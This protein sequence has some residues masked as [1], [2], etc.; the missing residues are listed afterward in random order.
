MK[1]LHNNINIT[2][3]PENESGRGGD[4]LSAPNNK[5]VN[6]MP[7]PDKRQAKEEGRKIN[8]A[9]AEKGLSSREIEGQ[10]LLFREE[11]DTKPKEYSIKTPDG[12][13]RFFSEEEYAKMC[14]EMEKVDEDKNKMTPEEQKKSYF[15]EKIPEILEEKAQTDDYM[16]RRNMVGG[17]GS[18][19]GANPQEP[20]GLDEY[21][22][23]VDRWRQKSENKKRQEE[24]EKDTYNIMGAVVAEELVGAGKELAQVPT[25][26]LTDLM[27]ELEKEG[28]NLKFMIAIVGI[29]EK[30]VSLPFNMALGAARD[31]E[32]RY[33]VKWNDQEILKEVA[34]NRAK[35]RDRSRPTAKKAAE[36]YESPIHED[37]YHNNPADPDNNALAGDQRDLYNNPGEG[38]R[39]V[40]RE[41]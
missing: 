19:M 35:D 10:N 39:G 28:M 20:L 40:G 18:S 33:G 3:S 24:F 36:K 25:A 17:A 8:D 12:E 31:A 23:M 22:A 37:S 27:K 34:D 32:E 7:T 30:A 4:E 2:R 14:Q 6:D 15:E 21:E 5:S 38:G 1:N 11:G 26:M 29:I 16:K 41:R 13:Y 9:I